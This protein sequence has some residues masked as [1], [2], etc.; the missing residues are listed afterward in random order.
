MTE[1]RGK[2]IIP[3][4][5]LNKASCQ[6]YSNVI[7]G[8]FQY[9]NVTSSMLCVW[10]K[11]KRKSSTHDWLKQPETVLYI[12]KKGEVKS[13]RCLY[14][15]EIKDDVVHAIGGLGLHDYNP[16][17][18]GFKG[19]YAD[20]LRNTYHTAIGYDGKEWIGVYAKGTGERMRKLMIDKLGCTI[21]ILLDGGHIAAINTADYKAN[22]R[23]PQ[24]N[25]IQFI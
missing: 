4:H 21:A 20:V 15:S 14:W 1:I 18:E 24:N 7:S 9:R 5:S 19:R 22:T 2:S 6:S 12:N 11:W 13:Q 17:L 3:I 10:G 8:T 25:M 16:N 23:Q